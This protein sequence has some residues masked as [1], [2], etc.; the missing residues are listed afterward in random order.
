M[1]LLAD[2][3]NSAVADFSCFVASIDTSEA[4]MLAA[5]LLAVMLAAVIGVLIFTWGYRCGEEHRIVKP[6]SQSQPVAAFFKPEADAAPSADAVNEDQG[7]E[8][9]DTAPAPSSRIP[10]RI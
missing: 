2:R 6:V 9:D 5:L 7:G 10:L 1:T 4:L 8:S 3:S